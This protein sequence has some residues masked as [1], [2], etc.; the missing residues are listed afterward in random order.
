MDPKPIVVLNFNFQNK[1][2]KKPI[3]LNQND[4]RMSL[5][6]IIVET[7]NNNF[8]NLLS[9]E[10][11]CIL[12]TTIELMLIDENQNNLKINL[13]DSFFDKEIFSAKSQNEYNNNYKNQ[14]TDFYIEIDSDINEYPKSYLSALALFFIL[15][16]L[17]N[18]LLHMIVNNNLE[19]ELTKAKIKILFAEMERIVLYIASEINKG[20]SSKGSKFLKSKY[21]TLQNYINYICNLTSKICFKNRI[22]NLNDINQYFSKIEYN[23]FIQSEDQNLK[24]FKLN[25]ENLVEAT[26]LNDSAIFNS[27][28]ELERFMK[29]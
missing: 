26:K 28:L 3:F 16:N 20:N 23:L 5:F 4:T 7:I 8:D 9:N 18:I 22:L 12:A 21:T 27:L 24:Q 25:V 17:I 2:F 29:S 14:K 10:N 6:S 11:I 19:I 13:L 1:I 15:Q